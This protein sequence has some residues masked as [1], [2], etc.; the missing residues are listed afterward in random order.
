MAK[1]P[2]SA[3][4][5]ATAFTDS[6][7][8]LNTTSSSVTS[9]RRASSVARSTDTPPGWPVAGSVLARMGLPRLMD[10]RNAPVGA[11]AESSAWAVFMASLGWG[12]RR[13][14]QAI[15]EE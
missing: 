7:A 15:P 10:A 3:C 12:P 13:R 1:K 14:A 6:P 4:S 9:R 5:A 8:D 2:T 11:K